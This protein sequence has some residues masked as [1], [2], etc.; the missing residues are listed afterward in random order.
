MGI[1][2]R[3][4]FEPDLYPDDPVLPIYDQ[5]FGL[6]RASR[7]DMCVVGF[8]P[9]IHHTTRLQELEAIYRAQGWRVKIFTETAVDEKDGTVEFF[10]DRTAAAKHRE[11][12]ASLFA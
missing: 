8:E 10:F 1:Q 3:K 5:L 2:I 12:G 11:W 7:N 4:I 9:N 6:E